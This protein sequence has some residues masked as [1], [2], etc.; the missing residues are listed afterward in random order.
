MLNIVPPKMSRKIVKMRRNLIDHAGSSDQSA[1]NRLV[2]N[3]NM[4]L[5]TELI[6]NEDDRKVDLANIKQMVIRNRRYIPK[7]V[8]VG[9]NAKGPKGKGKGF[10][11]RSIRK[12]KRQR[13]KKDRRQREKEADSKQTKTEEIKRKKKVKP[14]KVLFQRE[15][16]KEDFVDPQGSEHTCNNKIFEK[17]KK[18]ESGLFSNLI[19]SKKK[20]I[21]KK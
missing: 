11:K 14:V 21:S 3:V 8:P 10:S 12:M 17:K 15:K 18:K 9:P 5:I 13:K 4:D 6:N 7:R 2:R 16:K 1:P 20:N 19:K